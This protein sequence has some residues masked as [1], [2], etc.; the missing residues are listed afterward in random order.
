MVKMARCYVVLF[1]V[2]CWDN[3]PLTLEIFMFI[4]L[5]KKLQDGHPKSENHLKFNS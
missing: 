4:V 2:L 5:L 3:R 1:I